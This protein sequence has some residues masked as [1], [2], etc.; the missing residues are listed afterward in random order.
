MLPNPSARDPGPEWPP[1]PGLRVPPAPEPIGQGRTHR[2]PDVRHIEKTQETEGGKSTAVAN[3]EATVRPPLQMG[4]IEDLAKSIVR[5]GV[6][7]SVSM[8]V[9]PSPGG[10]TRVEPTKRRLT[11]R[12]D[13]RPRR[14]R[15]IRRSA[16]D[17]RG[18]A[19]RV[20]RSAGCFAGP[21][22]FIALLRD[23]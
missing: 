18:I 7:S 13:A 4:P 14:S 23:S 19:L 5:A 20:C 6:G 10:G 2:G 17:F 3:R 15:S 9:R 1:P 16:V 22:G 21:G 12:R 8:P 11:R